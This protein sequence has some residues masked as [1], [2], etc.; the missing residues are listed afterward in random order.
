MADIFDVFKFILICFCDFKTYKVSAFPGEAEVLYP[1]LSF[2]RPTG[3]SQDVVS[4]RG[5]VTV[6]E[7]IPD[8]SA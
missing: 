5:T 6:I 7:V 2:L 8:M 3:R 1:P 4:D